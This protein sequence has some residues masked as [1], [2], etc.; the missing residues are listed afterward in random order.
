MNL[1]EL[2]H[3]HFK[4]LL[5]IQDGEGELTPELES[6]LTA[7]EGK[8][9]DKIEAVVCVLKN[10]DA[11]SEKFG[12]EIKRLSEIKKV[13][14]GKHER[15]KNWVAGFIG[16]EGWKRGVHK[17]SWRKSEVVEADLEN[18]PIEY[19]RVAYS[20]DKATIKEVL[21]LGQEVKGASLVEKLNLQV[22]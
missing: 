10:L 21:K 5:E 11:E 12:D 7:I 16:P 20:A 22:K 2:A 8:L 6:N 18:L 9:D 1:Y 14:E 17:L 4:L 19:Q 3:E 15:L 13:V